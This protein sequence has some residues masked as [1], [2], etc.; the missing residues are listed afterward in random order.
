MVSTTAGKHP[1]GDPHD[2][3]ST[4]DPTEIIEDISN[5]KDT[6]GKGESNTAG[7]HDMTKKPVSE[8]VWVKARP[9]MHA[10]A[11]IADTWER[12]SNALSPTPPFPTRRPRLTLAACLLPLLLGSFFTT[13]YM[14]LKGLGFVIGF[15]F[16]GE[17]ILTRTT[18]L[19]ERTYPRW[20][21]YV[22]LRNSILRGVP[23]NAQLTM[24][25]LRI[26]E[27]NKA[28]V[29]PPPASEGP[30]PVQTNT[31]AIQDLGHLGE[32]SP[33]RINSFQH[34]N[35]RATA[36]TE[37]EVQN[38]ASVDVGYYVEGEDEKANKPKKGRRIVNAIKSTV[39]GGIN[40]SLI[41]DKAKAAVGAH[42]AKDRR[43][44]VKSD[45]SRPEV[46][47]VRFQARY[48][49][50]KGHAYVTVSATSQA[51][52]WTSNIDDVN[53]AW[54]VSIAEINEL[55][56]IGGLGWKSKIV[57]AWALDK[58]IVDGLVIQ[59][60]RGDEFHLTAIMV[61]DELFNRLIAMGNQ[62]WEA[63]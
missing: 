54:T 16:F 61:R 22:E 47:P 55:K 41:A 44:V 33:L 34:A 52:S 32:Q 63:W 60:K 24:T 1:Q 3:S 18:A 25:L 30:P 49:G 62:M 56:K 13:S 35:Q 12:F 45:I 31:E 5:A 46:G 27:R 17:P 28:P 38:A 48:K 19:L 21:K 10:L 2:D 37:G 6:T 43:G 26:G 8:A 15:V 23:T 59:T 36:A 20:Q 50:Q 9:T 14:M 29:P 4:P 39:G 7:V 53:P 42:Q 11:D 58:Q 57:V 51:L 40:V